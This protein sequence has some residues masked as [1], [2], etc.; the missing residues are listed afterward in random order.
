MKKVK[1]EKEQKKNV[2]R[3]SSELECFK[4]I[5]TCDIPIS[6]ALHPEQLQKTITNSS[7][8]EIDRV[9]AR[10][11]LNKLIQKTLDELKGKYDNEMV[12]KFLKSNE[13]NIKK[14]ANKK[15]SNGNLPKSKSK[16]KDKPVNI[17]ETE[18]ET[19]EK[20]GKTIKGKTPVQKAKTE[21]VKSLKPG[22]FVKS[23]SSRKSDEIEEGNDDETKQKPINKT[24]DPFFVDS[25]GQNYL[26]IVNEAQSSDDSEQEE[27][28]YKNIK[29]SKPTPK[30]KSTSY[31]NPTA[32]KVMDV[33]EAAPKPEEPVIHPSWQAK[34]QMKK[35]Q[36]Q[37]FKGTKIKFDD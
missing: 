34:Q 23:L 3:K 35:L 17:N 14:S 8:I 32:E 1:K 10:I 6:L 24:A 4:R 18:V 36:V 15:I 11:L 13:K 30:L 29:R 9:I 28:N 37:E 2:N 21:S 25:S 27:A 12:E 5:K 16:G 22:A 33:V 7:S 19:N 26:A 31:K 20:E